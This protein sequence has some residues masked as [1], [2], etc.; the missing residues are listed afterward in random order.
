MLR[1]EIG[2][3]LRPAHRD[4]PDGEAIVVHGASA[5]LSCGMSRAASRERIVAWLEHLAPENWE[6]EQFRQRATQ[7]AREAGE[8]VDRLNIGHELWGNWDREFA[9]AVRIAAFDRRGNELT[10]KDIGSWYD[11]IANKVVGLLVGAKGTQGKGGKQIPEVEAALRN[12]ALGGMRGKICL[13]WNWETQEWL[14]PKGDALSSHILKNESTRHWLSAEAAIESYCQAALA[15]AGIHACETGARVYNGIATVVSRRSDRFDERD[16]SPLEPVHQEEWS[17]AI[18]LLPWEKKEDEGER[19]GWEGLLTLLGEYGGRQAEDE[20]AK[21]VKM[22]AGIVLTANTDVHRRNIGIQHV[23]GHEGERIMMAP[24]YDCSS[25]EG[26]PGTGWK[27]MELPIGGEIEIEEIGARHWQR[28]AERSGARL[29][30]VMNAVREVAEA[31]PEA[32]EKADTHT[33]GRDETSEEGGRDMR[34]AAIKAGARERC[35]KAL[36]E[37]GPGQGRQKGAQARG[38]PQRQETGEHSP[39]RGR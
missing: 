35:A 20:Q 38:A 32:L 17:Q 19:E 37:L 16:G 9:G 25:I 12:H 27:A 29:G 22:M 21:L 39:G 28:I 11:P 4:W 2:L 30:L 26:V 33:K 23:P 18:G 13:R 6:R 15:Y 7:A 8:R 24:Q 5:K 10:H 31:L 36:R 34:V 14:I 3:T 1:D